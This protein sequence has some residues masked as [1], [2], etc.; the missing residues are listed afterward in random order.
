MRDNWWHI[1]AV[2]P[3]YFPLAILFILFTG[4]NPWIFQIVL[5]LVYPGALY[6]DVKY[7]NALE[8]SWMPS[9]WIYLGIGLIVMLSLG[10]LSLIV[11]PIYLYKR[12]K[13]VGTP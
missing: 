13:Y 2:L 4:I 9:K 6:L 12:R 1:I 10:L 5:V 3:L 7:V 11:S 8:V